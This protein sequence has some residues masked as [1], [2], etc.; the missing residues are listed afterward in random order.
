[1][2]NAYCPFNLLNALATTTGDSLL[3]GAGGFSITLGF[4]WHIR[5]SDKVVWRTLQF[6]TSN[7]NSM[8]MSINVLEFVTVISTIAP[9]SMLFGHLPA[10]TISIL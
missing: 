7:N 3:E 9:H 4:W 6:K 8:L 10:Q 5:F 2:G 1:M